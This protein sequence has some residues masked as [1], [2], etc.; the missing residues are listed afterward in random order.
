MTLD[1]VKELKYCILH[2]YSC[3][4]LQK[5]HAVYVRYTVP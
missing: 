2:Y 4:V 5:N 1:S 3:S